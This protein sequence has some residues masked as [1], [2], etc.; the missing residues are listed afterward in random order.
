M[1][2]PKAYRIVFC[3]ICGFAVLI[4]CIMLV[5]LGVVCDSS[6]FFEFSLIFGYGFQLA[7]SGDDQKKVGSVLAKDDVEKAQLRDDQCKRTF[8]NPKVPRAS[9]YS[10]SY[11]RTST[12]KVAPR[13][14]PRDSDAQS[15]RTR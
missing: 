4:H 2:G 13:K 9:S 11:S 1:K 10:G 15:R 7:Y 3:C 12:V 14:I 6:F 8:A 5:F